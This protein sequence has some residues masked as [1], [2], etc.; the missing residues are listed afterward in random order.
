MRKN[1]ERSSAI[2]TI[3]II[4]SAIVVAVGVIVA[5]KKI[6]DKY[7]IIEKKPKKKFIDFD[8]ADDWVIDECDCSDLDEFASELADDEDTKI[9]LLPN[10]SEDNEASAEA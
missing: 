8:D 7:K 3:I 10:D 4:A 1:E 9:E 6:C 2:T 5:F